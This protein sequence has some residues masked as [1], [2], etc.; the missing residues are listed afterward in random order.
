M[1]NGLFKNK[2]IGSINIFTI[3]RLSDGKIVIF[4]DQSE[5][6]IFL[7]LTLLLKQKD[8]QLNFRAGYRRLQEIVK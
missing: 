3:I 7:T 2:A 8:L 4:R 1:F 6:S 5:A